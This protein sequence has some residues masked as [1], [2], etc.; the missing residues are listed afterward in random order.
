MEKEEERECSKHGIT[1]FGNYGGKWRCKA[2]Q[3]EATQKRREKVKEMAI[4]YKG[5][6]CSICGY[7]KCVDALEFHHLNPN[8]KDFGI[9]S[10]GYTLSWETVKE[11]LDKCILVCANCHRELHFN[12]L[13][14]IVFSKEEIKDSI[15]NYKINKKYMCIDCGA[16]LYDGKAIRCVP[17]SKLAL[18]KTERPLKEELF[19]LIKIKSFTELGKIYGVC[20]NSIKKWCKDYQLPSTKRELKE[21]GLI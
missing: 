2:C 11:E 14:K 15:E 1:M 10:K 6:K 12:L 7:N 9:S 18:R 17:C 4:M 20:D 21:L 5:D 3:V 8:E 16:E 13:N 19:E